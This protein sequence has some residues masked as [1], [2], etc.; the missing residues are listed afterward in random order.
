MGYTHSTATFKVC[1]LGS[2]PTWNK[3]RNI[4][5]WRTRQLCLRNPDRAFNATPFYKVDC[6]Q[7]EYDLQTAGTITKFKVT[8][9]EQTA[10]L[11]F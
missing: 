1:V 5:S 8:F 11:T 7:A 4:H 9:R 6:L 3:S 2:F 10:K